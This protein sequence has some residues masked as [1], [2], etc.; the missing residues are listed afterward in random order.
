MGIKT[1]INSTR[2][3]LAIAFLLGFGLSTLFRKS[4]KDESCMKFKAPSLKKVEKA[5]YMFENKCYTF[6]SQAAK[7]DDNKRIVQF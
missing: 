1:A 2:G 3:R 6:K 5:P 7:C 4:C